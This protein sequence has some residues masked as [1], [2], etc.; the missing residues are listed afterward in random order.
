MKRFSAWIFV[1]LLVWS[2]ALPVCA[3]G[4]NVTYDGS[5][6]EF[7][8]APGSDYSPT[9]LFTEFKDVMPGDRLVQEILVRNTASK[10]VEVKIYMRALGAHEDSKDFLSKLRLLVEKKEEQGN[11]LI[12]DATASEKAQIIDWVCLGSFS[13]GSEAVLQVI[14][15]VPVELDNTY[16]SQIGKLDWEFKV[17][18]FPIEEDEPQTPED[19]KDSTVTTPTT[20]DVLWGAWQSSVLCCVASLVLGMLWLTLYVNEKRKNE[21]S[22]RGRLE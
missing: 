6:Q 17:E 21:V 14:L 22:G 13:H 19:Q 4:G 11:V 1:W 7:I 3:A 2:M 9:D 18:E 20:G 12:F 16:S 5:A 15:E 8:F 10:D